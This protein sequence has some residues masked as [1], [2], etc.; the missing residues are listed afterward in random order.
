MKKIMIVTFGV[1][2]AL[3]EASTVL[4]K[5]KQARP[6]G[7]DIVSIGQ[8]A[9]L[10]EGETA[11]GMV[12]IGGSAVVDGA[13][14]GDVVVIGGR[15][16][17]SSSVDGDLV[18]LGSVRLGPKASVGG[19]TVVIGG[20]L[21]ADPAAEI[22]GE[23][24][25][26]SLQAVTPFAGEMWRWVTLGLM[27]AR[28]LPFEVWWV[29]V[30]ALSFAALYVLL[31]AGAPGAVEACAKTLTERPVS[32]LLSGILGLSG[33][34][35]FAFLLAVSIAGLA[36]IP[37]LILAA[38]AAT[39][40]GKAAL[41][42]VLGGKSG[43]FALVAAT[44]VGSA[45]LLALYAVPVL[46]LAVWALS[47]VFGFG[48]ALLAGVEALKGESGSGPAAPQPEVATAPTAEAAAVA[49]E[50]SLPRAEFG[51]KVAAMA[52]DA[53]AFLVIC[54]VMPFLAV[55]LGGWALYQVGM[56]VWKGTTLGGMIMGIKGVRLDGR[57]MDITVAL[58]RHL[59]SY[60][61][62]LP[63]F[64]G[65]FWAGWDP[66]GQSWHDKIAGTV[67]VKQKTR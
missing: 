23:K 63:M 44:A 60:L 24:T 21:E 39:V 64:L 32:A 36:V 1:V 29:W 52:F 18:V 2:L 40:L 67:V 8:S 5:G 26:I 27:K 12:V 31:A 15:A 3:G 37:L 20:S 43:K 22:G 19:D 65:F 66:E 58:V 55:G 56:W 59:A 6:G 16:D 53:F 57:P 45:E 54:G 25:L 38:L 17:V 14:D 47:T 33:L 30:L 62:A 48:A 42:R 13:V 46:G 28:A 11:E 10:K 4:A 49:D 61:S 51:L 35:P 9:V 41:C 50:S 7:S 34:A